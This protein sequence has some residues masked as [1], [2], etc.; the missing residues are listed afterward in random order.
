MATVISA[1][2]HAE[3]DRAANDRKLRFG[4]IIYLITDIA[5]AIFLTA[6]YPFL[7]GLNTDSGWFPYRFQLDFTS[8]NVITG[9]LVASGVCYFIGYRALRANN[10]GIFK[11]GTA[12]AVLLVLV[13]LVAQISVMRHF[14]FAA[15]DGS[16]A[17]TYIVLSGYHTYHLVLGAFFG[18][19]LANRALRG[20]YSAENAIGVRLIGYY[21]LWA[22]VYSVVLSALP[23]LLPPAV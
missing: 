12:L 18:L 19:G 13:S 10:Q 9:L 14:P 3:T 20:R 21:W 1:Q 16:F 23:H 4:M 2:G 15:S 7:R 11:V 5:F 22:I 8:G 17:S 6:A